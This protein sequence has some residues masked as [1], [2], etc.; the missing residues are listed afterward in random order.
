[1]CVVSVSLNPRRVGVIIKYTH[2]L[3]RA[4]DGRSGRTCRGVA[5][6]V[7]LA[8]FEKNFGTTRSLWGERP[9]YLPYPARL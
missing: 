5:E 1:M 3:R 2:T 9:A 8:N 7:F 4:Q 6:D